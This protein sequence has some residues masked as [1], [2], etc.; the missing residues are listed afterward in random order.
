M[1]NPFPPFG[2]L[3]LILPLKFSIDLKEKILWIGPQNI[4]H[5]QFY[6]QAGGGDCGVWLMICFDTVLQLGFSFYPTWDLEVKSH[7]HNQLI[8]TPIILALS[9]NTSITGEPSECN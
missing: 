9:T 7:Y 6:P 4:H 1:G 5:K 3:F 2:N 8:I